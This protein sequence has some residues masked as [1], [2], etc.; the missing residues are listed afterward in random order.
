MYM[1]DYRSLFPTFSY[2]RSKKDI[3][4]PPG[5]DREFADFVTHLRRST[6]TDTT[7]YKTSL[8]LR[9]FCMLFHALITGRHLRC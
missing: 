8:F 3:A 9:V 5:L 2:D 7:V 1:H 4:V 6:I